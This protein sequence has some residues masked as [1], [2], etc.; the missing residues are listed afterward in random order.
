MLVEPL[1]L[2]ASHLV[3]RFQFV[4]LAHFLVQTVFP[5]RYGGSTEPSL[6]I[7]REIGGWDAFY[8]VRCQGIPLS[9][10]RNPG[11]RDPHPSC[12]RAAHAVGVES[13]CCTNA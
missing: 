12:C 6:L 7:E 1:C 10:Q 3:H 4:S 5:E 13:S 2:T 8:R 9:L 11:R